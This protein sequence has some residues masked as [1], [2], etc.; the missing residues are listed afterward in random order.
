MKLLKSVPSLLLAF[1]LAL[2]LSVPALALEDKL[3]EEQEL[4]P[5]TVSTL[6][7][8]LAAIGLAESGDNIILQNRIYIAEN[9]I[10]GQNGKQITII[11][12]NDFDGNTMFQIQPYEEQN[13]IFQNVVLD[14]QNKS[15]LSALEVNFYGVPNSKG[16]FYLT[17]IQVKN[18]ISSHSNIFINN[19]SAIVNDCQFLDNTAQRTAGVEIA[20][21]ATGKISDCIFSGNASLGNGGALRCEGQVQIES[22]AITQNQ[23][24]NSNTAVIGGG[25]YIGQ[26]AYCEITDCQ[27]SDN[28]AFQGGGVANFGNA[29]IIDTILCKN[30]GLR[31]ANDIMTFSSEQFVLNYSDEMKSVYAENDPIGFYLDD[32]D[33][34]FDPI[35]NAIFLGES[36][37]K[38]IPVNRYGA[39]FVFASELP[40]SPPDESESADEGE[41]PITPPTDPQEPD[42]PDT[43]EPTTTPD[44]PTVPAP[45][46]PVLPAY[47]TI[48]RPTRPVVQTP[49]VVQPEEAPKLELSC[50][51][52]TLDT[53][54]PLVLLGYGDGQ[55]HENDPITRAQIVVLL[56]R[57]LTDNSN[58]YKANANAFADVVNGAWYYDAVT[59]LSSV[60]VINGCDGLFL[61]DDTLTYGQL[62][63]ILTRFVEPKET[64]VPDDLPYAGHWAYNNIV[65]AIAYGWIDS[66]T[67]IEP[68]RTITRG[69]TVE[70]VNSIFEKL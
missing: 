52:I 37:A 40:Q 31:G 9:C 16:T 67:G 3:P 27:I 68:D 18:F 23:A 64:P 25:I 21:N 65:T 32:M 69:E 50:G 41:P 36:L 53:T 17:G 13:I 44:E 47:P 22:T 34:R 10:I 29:V 1:L 59:V 5:A 20:T 66:A 24:V 43:S 61:P 6:D 19:I 28:T 39:T 15:D 70:I 63:A 58:S 42:T 35:D 4:A 14:G 57:S 38:D 2:L 51:G 12:A 33:N 62:I 8:L 55:L 26:Q 46:P 45:T 54:I 48:S 30:H 60:G 11:P 49:P 56:Y 7:E